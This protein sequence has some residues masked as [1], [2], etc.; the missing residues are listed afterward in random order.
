MPFS[1]HFRPPV[2]TAPLRPI[3][4]SQPILKKKRIDPLH[5]SSQTPGSF[6]QLQFIIIMS[7]RKYEYQPL[8]LPVETR[9]LVLSPGQDDDPLTGTL[10]P[11]PIRCPD[12][13]YTALSYCWNQSVMKDA[14]PPDCRLI[15][16]VRTVREDGSTD[17]FLEEY[18]FKDMLNHPLLRYNYLRLGGRLPE[19]VM[20]LD[21]SP[22]TIGGELSSALRQLRDEH[23]PEPLRIWVDALCID[24]S[25]LAERNEHVQL[26]GQIYANASH[27]HIWL[28]EM[29][30]I[31]REFMESVE[32]LAQF[33]QGL[34]T[35]QELDE[36]GAIAHK[37]KV[38]WDFFNSP[39]VQ[40]LHWDKI[41]EV[42]DR[43]WASGSSARL[44]CGSYTDI[45]IIL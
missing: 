6:V 31:E 22:V 4:H 20:L 24:Q 35:T 16:A 43:A 13:P 15:C 28:G 39:E 9:I 3:F 44:S 14:P 12:E 21:G 10:L 36:D 32:K 8:N 11:M 30:G 26:M 45:A 5:Y 23:A 33:V 42:V 41:A 34:L 2:D 37:Y 25:N 38:Q 29:M 19:G 1:P 27:V 7:D 18:A 17:D 40:E